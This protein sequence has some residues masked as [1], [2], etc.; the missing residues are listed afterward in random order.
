MQISKFRQSTSASKSSTFTNAVLRNAPAQRRGGYERF[1]AI[2]D[3]SQAQREFQQSTATSQA[4]SN[5]V[6][7]TADT[8]YKRIENA[9][10]KAQYAKAAGQYQEKIAKVRAAQ[11]NEPIVGFDNDGKRIIVASEFQS[12]YEDSSAAIQDEIFAAGL[13]NERAIADFE[14]LKSQVD[15]KY[16]NDIDKQ[17]RTNRI[18]V[19]KGDA[20][21]A[22]DNA[23][24]SQQI[25]QITKDAAQ[26]GL[27]TFENAEKLAKKKTQDL[28]FRRTT[29]GI[30][31]LGDA[32]A[33]QRG[34]EFYASTDRAIFDIQNKV[35]DGS[36]TIQQANALTRQVNDIEQKRDK[37]AAAVKQLNTYKLMAQLKIQ[38]ANSSGRLTPVQEALLSGDRTMI[39][40]TVSAIGG[41]N[42][43]ALINSAKATKAG[44]Q[45]D[46]FAMNEVQS[47]LWAYK[48]NP[49]PENYAVFEQE[50]AKNASSL[51]S[52]YMRLM[53]EAGNFRLNDRKKAL[54]TGVDSYAL[55]FADNLQQQ[56]GEYTDSTTIQ[57]TERMRLNLDAH[58]R[59]NPEEKRSPK[60][61]VF[62]LGAK[63]LAVPSYVGNT[64]KDLNMTQAL[65]HVNDFYNENQNDDSTFQDSSGRL[66][67]INEWKANEIANLNV[68]RKVKT[69]LD[70]DVETRQ[71]L[72]D[73][74]LNKF[75]YTKD[76]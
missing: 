75:G 12:K 10:H 6:V 30:L 66:V 39:D 67:S 55:V 71:Q 56:A 9:E 24:T 38:E 15:T 61:I 53:E 31:N 51:G 11:L 76:E 50:A 26:S 49:T 52:Q 2:E 5:A 28:N 22:L 35:V 42:T 25:E 20:I 65:N 46:Q 59:N 21:E 48:N 60:A 43:L 32:G 29:Q 37:Q 40:K 34:E 7:K 70:T 16:F 36:L 74:V 33:A 45:P 19:A 62:E 13:T 64:L 17:Y 23:V 63:D 18:N 41:A 72:S 1:V 54:D 3:P 57:L 27:F 68:L 73:D 44:G 69:S 58:F 14:K 47:F 4:V 8:V